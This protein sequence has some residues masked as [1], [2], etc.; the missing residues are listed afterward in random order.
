M[1]TSAGQ[2]RPALRWRLSIWWWLKRNYPILFCVEAE[3]KCI[4]FIGLYNLGEES[5]EITLIVSDSKSRRLGFGSEAYH[6]LVAHLPR[7]S[8]IKK[9]TVRV[10][11]DNHPSISFWKALGFEEQ[12]SRNGIR[13][14]EKDLERNAS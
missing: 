7:T 6:A 13:T 1:R 4:G 8:L 10:M 12:H 2:E 9:V 14:M 5:A 11:A 3:S